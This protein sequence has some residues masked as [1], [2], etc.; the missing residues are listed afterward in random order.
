LQ[1]SPFSQMLLPHWAFLYVPPIQ[2]FGQVLQFSRNWGS[3]MPFPHLIGATGAFVGAFVGFRVGL[4]TGTLVGDLVGLTTA[5]LYA[6]T[7]AKVSRMV[8]ALLMDVV[9]ILIVLVLPGNV[10]LSS[11]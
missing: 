9:P 1:F 3:Q 8:L 11:G 2:S 7:V 4:F 6:A 10:Y 5:E